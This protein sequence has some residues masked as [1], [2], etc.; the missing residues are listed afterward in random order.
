MRALHASLARHRDPHMQRPD[1][2]TQ[3][4]GLSKS[5]HGAKLQAA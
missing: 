3:K 5:C 1:I 2:K 4:L